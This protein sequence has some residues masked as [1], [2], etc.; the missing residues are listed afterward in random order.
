MTTIRAQ[1]LLPTPIPLTSSRYLGFIRFNQHFWY[2][3]SRWVE[4]LVMRGARRIELLPSDLDKNY[5]YVIAANHQSAADPF[6]ICGAL[7]MSLWPNLGVFR[8][9]ANA[10]LFTRLWLRWPLLSFGSFPARKEQT[11]PYGIEAARAY[12]GRGQTV[13]MFPEGRRTLPRQSPARVG[14]AVLG[15]NPMV[16]IIPAR[17]QWTSGLRRG[18]QVTIGRPMRPQPTADA[19]LAAIYD[20]ELPQLAVK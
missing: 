7:P 15:V 14:V 13:V 8:Y 1:R 20:L 9:M 18:F 4:A 17:I 2:W 10:S 16:R 3:P 6:V 11:L 19:V 12:L 5:H